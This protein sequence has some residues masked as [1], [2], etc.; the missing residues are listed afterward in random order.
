MFSAAP[1]G[2]KDD[3]QVKGLFVPAPKKAPAAALPQTTPKVP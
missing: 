1:G 3:Q 2:N